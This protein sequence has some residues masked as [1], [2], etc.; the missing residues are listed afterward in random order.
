MGL[1][2][3]P[4]QC[5]T[6]SGTYVAVLLQK[7]LQYILSNGATGSQIFNDLESMRRKLYQVGKDCGVEP[8]ILQFER[9]TFS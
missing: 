4:M 2:K 1:F 9:Q 8:A 3:A 6:Y 7:L 5:T